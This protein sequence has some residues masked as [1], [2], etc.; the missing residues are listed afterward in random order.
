MPARPGSG[1]PPRPSA[2][3]AR[4]SLSPRAGGDP[5]AAILAHWLL[6]RRSISDPTDI[7]YYACYG[8]RRATVADLAWTA[9]SRWHVEECFQQ[10]KGEAGL[11]LPGPLLAGLVCPHHPVDARAGL[12]RRQQSPVPK[13]GTGTCDP[14]INVQVGD[15]NSVARRWAGS[16]RRWLSFAEAND[17]PWVRF[18]KDEAKLEVMT[19]H[20]ARQASTGRSGVAAIGVAQEF[21]RVWTAAEGKT[22]TG[23]PRWSFYKADR[24]VTCYYF[25]L[26]YAV[27]R[28]GVHQGLRLLPVSGQ[29]LAQRARVRQAPR[30]KAALSF[31]ALSNRSPPAT[32]RCPPDDL[33][34]AAACTIEVFAQRW[35]HQLPLPFTT[36]DHTPATGARSRC[37][38]RGFPHH[39]VRRTPPRPCLLRGPVAYNLYICRPH[40]VEIVFGPFRR[41][42]L[43]S[44]LYLPPLQL[45]SFQLLLLSLRI[46]R[47]SKLPSILI[48]TFF[49]SPL[50]LSSTLSF[51]TFLTPS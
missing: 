23:T 19:P 37:A 44:Y 38:S 35:L 17:I 43:P 25:Y 4:V 18:S 31:T 14:Y 5:T 48:Y 9:G 12:A 49:Y 1:C 13:R 11:A 51:P 36:R 2:R 42:T 15:G 6:A 8:P 39:R 34:P 22:S 47:T 24:R 40:N 45:S 21:Q 3:P 30:R 7:A 27:L 26:W 28:P 32:T 10:A 41:Y 16:A 29:D 50:Y 46:K 20:L 33:R